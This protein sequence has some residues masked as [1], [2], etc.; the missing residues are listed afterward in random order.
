[1]EQNEVISVFEKVI[2]LSEK[3][4]LTWRKIEETQFKVDFPRSSILLW[5]QWPHEGDYSRFGLNII[6][7]RGEYIDKIVSDE[8]DIPNGAEKLA[9]LFETVKRNYLKADETIKDILDGL[10][11]KELE[12]KTDEEDGLPF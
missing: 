7:A 5:M 11:A 12:A 3:K 10:R 8:T 6:N 1:M 9:K 2:E 4:K